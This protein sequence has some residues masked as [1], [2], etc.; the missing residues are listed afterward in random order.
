MVN[1]IV[2]F[3]MDLNIISLCSGFLF[4]TMYCKLH[5][6]GHVNMLFDEKFIISKFYNT[7]SFEIFMELCI[8]V[9]YDVITELTFIKI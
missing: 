7:F 6:I 9:T 8:S 4:Y 5:L 3:L 2:K 1:Q